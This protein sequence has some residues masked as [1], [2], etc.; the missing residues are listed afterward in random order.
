MPLDPDLSHHT[1]VV[2][3]ASSG[4][5]RAIAERLGNAGALVD[6]CGRTAGAMSESAS[7]ISAAGG[8]ASTVVGDVRNPAVVADLVDAAVAGTGR[9]DIFVH[10]AGVAYMT[11]ILDGDTEN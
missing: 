10:N 3:G 4:T 11:P 7:R 8:S 1:A 9:L 5:E 6:L 2:T